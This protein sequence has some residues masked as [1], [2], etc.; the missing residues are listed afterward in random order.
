MSFLIWVTR[1]WICDSEDSIA[2]FREKRAKRN[3]GFEDIEAVSIEKAIY[4][5]FFPLGECL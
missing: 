3:F 4:R 2:K 5:D 1:A